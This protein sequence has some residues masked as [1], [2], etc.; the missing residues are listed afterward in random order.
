MRLDKDICLGGRLNGKD[1]FGIKYNGYVL[2]KN[3]LYLPREFAGESDIT[4]VTTMV[5][6]T[7]TDLSRMFINCTN[8]T[9]INRMDEWNTSNVTTMNRMFSVCSS[10]TTLDLSNF[11]T[12]NVTDMYQMFGNC[13][14][15]ISIDVSSFDTSSVTNMW[16]MF[17]ACNALI[18]LDLSNFNTSNVTDIGYMFNGCQNLEKLNLS[19]F[20]T[21]NVSNTTWLFQ[22]CKNLK[23]LRLDNCDRN[24]IIK[25]IDDTGLPITAD[26]VVLTRKIYVNPDNVYDLTPPEDWI[27]VD[28]SGEEII[29]PNLYEVGEF[30]NN[31]SITEVSTLVTSDH[32]D[33]S[34]MFSGCSNLITINGMNQ[35]DTSNVTNM[36]SMFWSCYN[37]TAL[38]LNNFNTN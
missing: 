32:T 35:W 12:S 29:P 34:N 14:S 25:L 38:N 31:T 21:S 26:N 19:N 4:E 17:G 27:F 2:Y 18:E 3:I 5:N 7:H 28:S 15:L 10:L 13:T 1:I 6:E 9:T 30:K 37:L 22:S 11:D 16:G 23:E 20:D 36:A 24:T 8:L 33:L